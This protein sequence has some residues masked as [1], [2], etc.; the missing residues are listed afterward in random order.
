MTREGKENTTTTPK[1]RKGDQKAGQEHQQLWTK[2]E[3]R[4]MAGSKRKDFRG[5]GNNTEK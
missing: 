4:I 3:K 1:L 2:G 5:T